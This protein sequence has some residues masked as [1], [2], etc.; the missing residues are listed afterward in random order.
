MNFALGYIDGIVAIAKFHMLH[1]PVARPVVTICKHSTHTRPLI[2]SRRHRTAYNNN[3]N[4][5]YNNSATKCSDGILITMQ[6][7]LAADRGPKIT[8]KY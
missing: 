4:N 1:V 5:Y 8:R 7:T 2:M 6:Y 3:C